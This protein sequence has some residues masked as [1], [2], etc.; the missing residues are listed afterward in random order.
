MPLD[1]WPGVV[2]ATQEGPQCMQLSEQTRTPEGSENC[3]FLNVF[4]PEVK[5]TTLF[6]FQKDDATSEIKTKKNN[7]FMKF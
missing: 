4:V 5:I 1:P 7:E 2:D 3:L 6:F